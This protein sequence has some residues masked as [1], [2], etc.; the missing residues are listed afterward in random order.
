[1]AI[2]CEL[3]AIFPEKPFYWLF[4]NLPSRPFIL[5]NNQLHNDFIWHFGIRKGEEFC[6]EIESDERFE[7]FM[8]TKTTKAVDAKQIFDGK[9]V[10][11]FFER[12]WSRRGHSGLVFLCGHF[13]ECQKWIKNRNNLTVKFEREIIFF[14]RSKNRFI[15]FQWCFLQ[16][17]RPFENL[18]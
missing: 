4:S 1:M 6:S 11:I 9:I 18:Y 10:E 14:Q 2:K 16:H 8:E 13:W 5:S 15:R 7:W 3:K 17:V 12:N